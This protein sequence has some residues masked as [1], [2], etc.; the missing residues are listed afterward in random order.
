MKSHLKEMAVWSLPSF[1]KREGAP[2]VKLAEK[3]EASLLSLK[4]S[5]P[6]RASIKGRGYPRPSPPIALTR[7]ESQLLSFL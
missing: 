6:F 5:F 1:L 7:A 4:A 2:E 3:E